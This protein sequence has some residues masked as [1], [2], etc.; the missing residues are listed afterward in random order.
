MSTLTWCIVDINRLVDN[1]EDLR[2]NAMR[3]K[4]LTVGVVRLCR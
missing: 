2:E 3:K 4:L 1:T